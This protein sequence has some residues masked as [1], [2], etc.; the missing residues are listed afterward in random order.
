MKVVWKRSLALTVAFFVLVGL[1]AFFPFGRKTVAAEAS[2]FCGYGEQAA[3]A[4]L[5]SEFINYTRKEETYI[6]TAGGAPL[7]YQTSDY[8][9]SCGAVGGAMVVGFYDRYYTDLIPD[10][11]PMTPKGT[12]KRTDRVYIPQLIGELYTLMRTNVDDVGVSQADCLSGL[13]T[14]ISNHGRT[15]SYSSVA[16]S[17][18]I[19]ETAYV[20][21]INANKPMLLFCSK[22][23]LHYVANGSNMDE[24]G[25]TT[26]NGAHIAIAYGYIELKYYNESGLFRTDKYLQVGTGLSG[27]LTGYLKMNTTEWCNAAYAITVT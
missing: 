19:N 12:Y 10:Y 7:Y 14:Y 18:R 21:A 6:E 8:P 24:V 25:K 16:N 5:E 1:L 20:N 4:S 3:Y 2:R 23:D 27:S 9:N 17:N 15:M 22:M 13:S 11:D 26:L